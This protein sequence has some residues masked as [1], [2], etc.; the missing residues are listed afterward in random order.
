MIHRVETIIDGFK[1][2]VMKSQLFILTSIRLSCFIDLLD[3]DGNR[4]GHSSDTAA[5][6]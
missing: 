3:N 2:F 4:S 1:S 6:S 5:N